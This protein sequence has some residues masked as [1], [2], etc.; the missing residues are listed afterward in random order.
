MWAEDFAGGETAEAYSS[1]GP[2]VG[3][4]VLPQSPAAPGDRVLTMPEDEFV[5][6]LR[7]RL[8]IPYSLLLPRLRRER[9]P[10]QQCD[11]QNSTGSK[12]CGRRLTRAD[13][14]AGVKRKHPQ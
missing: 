6:S 4:F 7:A 14:T 1:G 13:R 5:E 10:A 9:G 2:H 11:H 12:I 3:D 8:R